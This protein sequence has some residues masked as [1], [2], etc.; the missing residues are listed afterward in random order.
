VLFRSGETERDEMVAA[1]RAFGLLAEAVPL[2]RARDLEPV[3]SIACTA[4]AWLPYEC[5]IE[6]RALTQAVLTAAAARGAKIRSGAEAQSL[7]TENHRCVGLEASGERILAMHVIVAAG[8]FS[9]SLQGVNQ[10]APTRPVRGQ[11]V[12]LRPRR[13]IIARVLRSHRG[14][15]VPRGDGRIVAGSTLEDA[16]FEKQVTP[17][18]ILQILAAALE[19]APEL[20]DATILETW[21]GLRPDTP[22][23]LPVLGATGIEGLWM[24]TGHYRN[25]ILLAP[26]T[27]LLIREWIVTGESRTDVRAFSPRRFAGKNQKHQAVGR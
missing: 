15:V 12:A 4:A 25:G 16:G 23:H 24:A 27:A 6:P 19:L 21:S 13:G 11:M 20:A 8:C 17:A 5:S 22:D 1:H 2:S 9:G 14:Y 26:I 3:A 18:G 10:F 7:I